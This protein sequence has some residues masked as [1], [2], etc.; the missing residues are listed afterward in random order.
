M[1]SALIPAR[2]AHRPC[3]N[4]VG[5]ARAVA[6][7]VLMAFAG[8]ASAAD[9][10]LTPGLATPVADPLGSG[11][12]SYIALVSG[13]STLSFSTGL[14]DGADVYTVGGLVGALNGIN[15]KVTPLGSA[16]VTETRLDGARIGSSTKTVVSAVTLDDVSGQIGTVG[17]VGG[18]RQAGTFII[19]TLT[20][21]YASVSNLRFDLRGGTVTA[22]LYGVRD[23]FRTRPSVTYDMPNVVLW[24]FDPNAVSGPASIKPEYLLAS[25]PVAALSNAGFTILAADPGDGA[26]LPQYQFAA[27]NVIPNL[28]ITTTGFN[29]LK[30]SL[31]LLIMGTGLYSNISGALVDEDG[32]FVAL[33]G[34]GSLTSRVVFT[35]TI[36][37]PS[38]YALMGLGLVGVILASRRAKR[39]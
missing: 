28:M 24:T 18:V 8:M 5:E 20:G 23:A 19:G 33:G 11:R 32:N 1:G 22:D 10:T 35:A 17:S 37:E 27:E 30:D 25:D 14:Y 13:T 36:P 39:H 6:L 38:T 34:Y 3:V 7:A 29:F 21:G 26:T 4:H 15:G 9:V 16:E 31:G 2:T 12:D